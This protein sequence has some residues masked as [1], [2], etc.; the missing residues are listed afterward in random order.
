MR[1]PNEDTIVGKV[2]VVP[3]RWTLSRSHEDAPE[4]CG[5]HLRLPGSWKLGSLYP[6]KVSGL[7]LYME[8]INL[9]VLFVLCPAGK[10]GFASLRVAL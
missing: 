6:P 8:E 9:L 2:P 4:A 5:P 3:G 7:G 1:S 10:V